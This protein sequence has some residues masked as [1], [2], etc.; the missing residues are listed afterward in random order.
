MSLKDELRLEMEQTRRDF[1]HLLDSV[2]EALYTCPSDNP[3]WTIREVLFHISL[4]PRFLSIDLQ[5]MIVQA[6]LARLLGFIFPRSAFDRLNEYLTRR[7]AR[8]ASRETLAL[9]YDKAHRHALRVLDRI[10]ES[11]FQRTLKYPSYDPLLGEMVT[12]EGLF[13]YIKTH[14]D[15]HAEQITLLLKKVKSS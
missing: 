9:E 10:S 15:A 8:N 6:W 1:H 5:R 13:R 2:P 11:D 14:F 12:V 4:V 7:W 3:A